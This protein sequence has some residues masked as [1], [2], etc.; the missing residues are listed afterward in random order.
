MTPLAAAGRLRNAGALLAFRPTPPPPIAPLVAA[1]RTPVGPRAWPRWLAALVGGGAPAR[2]APV[3]LPPAGAAGG[4]CVCVDGL[5]A[6]A[7]GPA[8]GAATAGFAAARA[9]QA[10][11][12]VVVPRARSRPA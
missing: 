11:F 7:A 4:W 8:A 12:A 3:A 6:G 5:A 2:P 1:R 10:P 9:A